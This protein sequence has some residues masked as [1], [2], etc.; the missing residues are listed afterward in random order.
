M[1]ESEL[2]ERGAPAPTGSSRTATRKP[3]AYRRFGSGETVCDPRPGDIVLIRGTGWLGK[4]I[5]FGT[6]IRCRRNGDDEL[7][8]WSHAGI[9]V[10][11]QGHLIEVVPRGVVLNHLENYRDQEY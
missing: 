10:S 7:A 9:I 11:P 6:R 3:I 1:S 8:H 5:R 4:S 2:K